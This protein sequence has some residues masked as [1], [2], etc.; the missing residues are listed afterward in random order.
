MAELSIWGQDGTV[1]KFAVAADSLLPSGKRAI[2]RSYRDTNASDPGRIRVVQWDVSGPIGNSLESTASVVAGQPTLATDF[3]QNLDTRNPKRLIPV[4]KRNAITLTTLDPSS[5]TRAKLGLFKLGA[6][7]LGATIATGANV[8]NFDEQGGRLFAHRGRLSSQINI[9][10]WLLEA[11]ALHPEPVTGAVDYF[12]KGRIGLGSPAKMRTRDSV[13]AFGSTYSETSTL[14]GEDVYAGVLAVGSD[15]CWFSTKGSTGELENLAGYTLDGFQT[16]NNPFAI[17][18]AK[19]NING[20]GPHGPFT[21]VGTRTGLFS[22]TDQAKPVAL[23]RALRGHDSVNNG[24]QWADPGWGWNYAITDVGLRAIRSDHTDNAVGVGE[25]MREFTG[26]NGRPTA[27]WAERGEMFIVYQTSAGDSYG[28]R[29]TFAKPKAGAIYSKTER[30]GQ[31]DIFPWWYKAATTCQSVFSTNTPTDTAMVWGEGTNMAYE[32]ISRDGRDDLFTSRQYGI[33]GGVWYGTELDRDPHLLKVL[34][35]SRV[36]TKG[37]TAGSSWTLAFTFD[38]G[39]YIDVGTVTSNGYVTLLPVQDAMAV[40]LDDIF[41]RTMKPRLRL[42][43][44]GAGAVTTPPEVIG[45][46]EVEYDEVPE[47]VQQV[48][49][50]L[51][52]AGTDQ[53]K[54]GTISSLEEYSGSSTTGPLRMRI[55]DENRDVWA[56]VGT[57]ANRRDAKEDAIEVIDVPLFIWAVA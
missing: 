23:S 24:S 22:Y 44:A 39:T 25:S 13:G 2:V 36:R 1:R 26:H 55:P 19:V 40:P 47:S 12:G 11:T 21:E 52:L 57:P 7:K 35:R 3:T 56:M 53:T 41:G 32:T 6:Q 16:I 31:P 34:R 5:A 46:L 45:P 15:R 48:M 20:I 51:Q 30:H 14:I 27:I 37:M 43:A 8:T 33:L 54:Q 18:D 28:Y 17:G 10:T 49:V 29:A 42:V 4:G 38:G 50:T 9:A